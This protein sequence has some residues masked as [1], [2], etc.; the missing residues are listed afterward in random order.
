[1]SIILQTAIKTVSIYIKKNLSIQRGVDA[2]PTP[3]SFS[4]STYV[5]GW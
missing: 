5:V 3:L 1:M 2:P 4:Q